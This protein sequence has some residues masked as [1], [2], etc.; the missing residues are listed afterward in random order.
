M[1]STRP[2]DNSESSLAGGILRSSSS[3][4]IGVYTEARFDRGRDSHYR[5]NPNSI[6]VNTI[7]SCIA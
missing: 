6:L 7:A 1:A 3:R 5:S 4:D 2:A